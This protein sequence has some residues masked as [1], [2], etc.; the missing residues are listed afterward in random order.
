MDSWSELHPK[1]EPLSGGKEGER[2]RVK[3]RRVGSEGKVNNKMKEKG[4]G[5]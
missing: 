5:V 3:E 4:G 1:T 2:E